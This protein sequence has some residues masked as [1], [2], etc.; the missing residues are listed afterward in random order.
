MDVNDTVL[1]VTFING[2]SIPV[3]GRIKDLPPAAVGMFIFLHATLGDP[4]MIN[5][6]QVMNI[7]EV[8]RKDL[9]I[10]P[11]KVIMPGSGRMN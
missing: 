1:M 7:R 5:L 6:D 2:I 3:E 11:S 9:Q 4:I 8:P 10:G